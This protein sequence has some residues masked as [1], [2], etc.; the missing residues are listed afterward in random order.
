MLQQ[1]A[2]FSFTPTFRLGIIELEK[3]E[4]HFNGFRCLTKAE[5]AV[6]KPLKWFSV[7][8]NSIYPQPEGWGE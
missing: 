5:L 3:L 2:N 4:N 1:E 7:Q 6:R 8:M